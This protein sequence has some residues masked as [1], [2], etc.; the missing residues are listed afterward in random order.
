[1]EKTA[2]RAPH[3][4]GGDGGHRTTFFGENT[5]HTHCGG[6]WVGGGGTRGG[7]AAGG[8]AGGGGGGE[9]AGGAVGGPGGGG[10]LGWGEGLIDGLVW[11]DLGCHGG[12]QGGDEYLEA[13][14]PRPERSFAQNLWFLQGFRKVAKHCSLWEQVPTPPRIQ[15]LHFVPR[16]HGGEFV[17]SP[18]QIS[19]LGPTPP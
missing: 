1:M 18:D 17:W 15:T 5:A 8:G 19:Y 11:P 12:S 10:G 13:P 4:R 7:G 2:H 14:F 9:W 3:G 16:R 6:R